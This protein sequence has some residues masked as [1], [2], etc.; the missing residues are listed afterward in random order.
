MPF[1]DIREKASALVLLSSERILLVN[2]TVSKYFRDLQRD[3]TRSKHSLSPA[4]MCYDK[5][6]ISSYVNN[7][8][9][10]KI[11]SP[12]TFKK[13]KLHILYSF[14]YKY[15]WKHF[16]VYVQVRCILLRYVHVHTGIWHYPFYN[17]IRS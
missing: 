2:D 11:I 13:F 16:T 1:C 12:T 14:F 15:Q 4:V 17:D 8:H 6:A 9:C 10:Y 3:T 5:H 7:N